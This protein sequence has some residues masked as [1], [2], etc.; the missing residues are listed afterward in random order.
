MVTQWYTY[1]QIEIPLMGINS[2]STITRWL[3]M[4]TQRIYSL[5]LSKM[6]ASSFALQTPQ[7]ASK[8]TKKNK[9]WSLSW[10]VCGLGNFFRRF[11]I[12]SKKL[13]KNCDFYK[14]RDP[15]PWYIVLVETSR[16][17]ADI[18]IYRRCLP[19]WQHHVITTLRQIFPTMLDIETIDDVRAE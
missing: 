19:Y 13:G 4:E 10:T 1:L 12:F 3:L 17:I 5:A 15:P 8:V 9:I 16:Y 6:I 7:Q 14:N 2:Q 18:V 11:T